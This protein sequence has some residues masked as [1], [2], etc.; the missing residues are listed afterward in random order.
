[1]AF[2]SSSAVVMGIMLNFSTST[3]R[4]F[5]VMNAGRMVQ[6]GYL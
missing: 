4:M 5:G 1:M 6:C 2:R 3:F